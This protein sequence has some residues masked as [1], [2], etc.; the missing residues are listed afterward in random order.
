MSKFIEHNSSG[1]NGPDRTSK[2]TNAHQSK[3]LGNAEDV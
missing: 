1:W 2:N 3:S